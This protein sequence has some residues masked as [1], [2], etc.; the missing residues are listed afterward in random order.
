MNDYLLESNNNEN[1]LNV[2]DKDEEPQIEL[3]NFQSKINEIKCVGKLM[4]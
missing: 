1:L 2:F 4:K 3:D